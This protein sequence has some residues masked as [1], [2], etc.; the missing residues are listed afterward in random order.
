MC[1]QTKLTSQ[2]PST[3]TPVLSL[4]KNP[5]RKIKLGKI[6]TSSYDEDNKFL[7]LTNGDIL[8]RVRV[9]ADVVAKETYPAKKPKKKSEAAKRA[10]GFITLDD[11]TSTLR[12]K[13]WEED[14]THLETITVGMLVEVLGYLQYQRG[15][16]VILPDYVKEIRDP[17]RAL[18]R[19]LELLLEKIQGK[20]ATTPSDEQVSPPKSILQA[21]VAPTQSLP[22]ESE[23]TI[24]R[25]I[26]NC[27]ATL[28]VSPE[29]KGVPY[30]EILKYC[31]GTTKTR[32][33]T[34]L[35]HL[36]ERGEIYSP[37]KK[38]FAIVR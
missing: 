32:I 21:D 24:I 33:K 14:L 1:P 16:I 38:Y 29:K 11:G 2:T 28:D 17:N 23:V 3:T 7:K 18:L 19:E 6:T 35:D 8:S 25:Q 15:E 31:K 9:M 22:K 12:V 13:A 26:L 27:L 36:L 34:T 4:N 20:K 30:L 37:K 10:W 5:A